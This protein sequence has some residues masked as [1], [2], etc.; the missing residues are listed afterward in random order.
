VKKLAYI[1]VLRGIAI[2]GVL[3]VHTSQQGSMGLYKM[4]PYLIPVLNQGARGVQLFYILSAFTLFRSY[5]IRSQAEDH[6]IKNFF[7]RR[8]FRIVPLYYLA[9]FYYLLQAISAPAKM[10]SY[11]PL[12]TSGSIIANFT[13]LHS[14]SPYWIMSI[15]PGG[16]SVAIEVIFYSFLPPLFSYIKTQKQAF[17]FF[18][19]SLLIRG[20]FIAVFHHYVLITNASLWEDFLFLSFPSQLYVFALGLLM[21]FLIT[22]D[23]KISVSGLSLTVFSF[24]FALNWIFDTDIILPHIL[25]IV[26]ALFIFSLALSKYHPKF[27]MNSFFIHLGKISYSIYLLHFAVFYWLTKLDVIDFIHVTNSITALFNFLIRFILVLILTMGIG[28]ISYNFIEQPF[29]KFAERLIEKKT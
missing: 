15:V 4:H 13:F 18:M 3:I 25:P 14:L 17:N 28:T 24:L 19:M 21:Y 23:F 12:I 29:I 27:L 26:L 11:N 5:H 20:I 1:N 22:D 10:L 6:P 8:V 7:I 16:W 2:L 9:I